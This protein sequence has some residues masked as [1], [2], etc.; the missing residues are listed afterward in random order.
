MSEKQSRFAIVASLLWIVLAVFVIL[1]THGDVIAQG[2][3]EI[4]VT[5]DAGVM[6]APATTQPK[7]GQC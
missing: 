3:N 2:A 6:L 7:I 5:P 4:S 1:G